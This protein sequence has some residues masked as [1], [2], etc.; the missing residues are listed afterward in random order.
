MKKILTLFIISLITIT[1]V[2]AQ[3]G[4]VSHKVDNRISVKFPNDPKD[5]T[6]G[7]F[8]T[9]D[10]DSVGYA[11]SVMDFVAMAG[12]D[13]VVLAP[14]KDTPE[15]MAELKQGIG[16]GLDGFIMGDFTIGKWK[17]FS[18]YT[19]TGVNS[20]QKTKMYIFLVF[21]QHW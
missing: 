13:S 9:Q 3:D 2:Y 1:I 20:A 16:S 18:S 5:V 10:K 7:T 8:E 4:W 17:G 19:I 21:V 6:L 11:L 12:I 14:L 15:F